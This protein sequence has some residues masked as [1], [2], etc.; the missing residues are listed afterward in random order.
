MKQI[1]LTLLMTIFGSTAFAQQTRD[2]P[3]KETPQS[4][5]RK[6]SY[7]RT[8]HKSCPVFYFTTGS[9]IN[10]NTGLLGVSFDK[11]VAKSVSVAGGIG[12]SSWGYKFYVGSTYYLKPCHRGF[13]FGGGLTYNTGLHNYQSDME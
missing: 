7:K 13:A 6:Q 2:N 5:E 3:T 4:S 9:G 12:I 11:P 8:K 1:T 10:N